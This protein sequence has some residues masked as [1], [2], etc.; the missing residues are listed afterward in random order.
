M[1]T[2]EHEFNYFM[3]FCNSIVISRKEICFCN[4]MNEIQ[5]LQNSIRIL[6]SAL[7]SLRQEHNDFIRIQNSRMNTIKL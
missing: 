7:E 3:I 4:G 5:E 2:S 6:K 1:K